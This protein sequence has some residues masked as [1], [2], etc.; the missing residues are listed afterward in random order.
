[1][2]FTLCTFVYIPQK[3]SPV[4]AVLSYCFKWKSSS[5]LIGG[6]LLKPSHKTLSICNLTLIWYSALKESICS[7]VLQSDWVCLHKENKPFHYCTQ[8][9]NEFL[10]QNNSFKKLEEIK[11]MDRML[12]T[13]LARLPKKWT[14]FCGIPEYIKCLSLCA[15]LASFKLSEIPMSS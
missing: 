6:A 1:M 15:L 5:H 2:L 9:N 8:S 12:N 4:I 11:F 13:F 7:R 10:F 14:M 3:H